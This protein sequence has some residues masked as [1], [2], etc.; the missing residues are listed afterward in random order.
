MIGAG[1]FL[2]ALGAW[3]DLGALLIA[4]FLVPTAFY[5]HGF[6]RERDP[7]MRM[8]QMAHFEKNVAMLGGALV[9]FYLFN[10]FGPQIGLTLG[11][12]RLFPHL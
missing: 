1:G 11:D 8:Q 5:M 12:G 6:W 10:Q 4:A 7:Q 2:V 3:V 9:L